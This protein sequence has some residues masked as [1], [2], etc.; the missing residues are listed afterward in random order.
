[1]LLLKI[2]RIGSLTFFRFSLY[3]EIDIMLNSKSLPIELNDQT[4]KKLEELIDTSHITLM[5]VFGSF[6]HGQARPKSD[7]DLLIKFKKGWETG[8][9]DFIRLQF[10][11]GKIFKRK[12]DLVTVAALSP[13][14]KNQVLADL[15][16]IYEK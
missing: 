9:L 15:K 6:A 10:K 7:L 11:L 16:V 8:L 5:G 12:V 4:R 1:M 13:Y 2:L 3:T 14:I